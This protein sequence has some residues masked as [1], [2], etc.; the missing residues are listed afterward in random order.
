MGYRVEI[1]EA[2][3]EV[4]RGFLSV[5]D[6]DNPNSNTRVREFSDIYEAKQAI[7]DTIAT[8]R[9]GMREFAFMIL[10]D[11]GLTLWTCYCDHVYKHWDS[12]EG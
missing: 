7:K 5:E 12:F 1:E 4:K 11:A 9:V 6:D 3:T 2:E 10:D 8:D